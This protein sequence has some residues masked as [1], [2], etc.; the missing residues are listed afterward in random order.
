M[1]EYHSFIRSPKTFAQI[2]DRCLFVVCLCD[3]EAIGRMLS[4]E[5]AG[6][7]ISSFAASA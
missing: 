4:D 1:K 2:S 5:G 7:K 3:A 6:G